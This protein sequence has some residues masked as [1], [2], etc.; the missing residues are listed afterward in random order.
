MGMGIL[1]GFG[2]LAAVSL[3]AFVAIEVQALVL[4]KLRVASGADLDEKIETLDLWLDALKRRSRFNGTILIARDGSVVFQR[5]IGVADIE[6]GRPITDR[7]AFNLASVSKHITAFSVLLLEHEGRLSRDDLLSK[8]LPELGRFDGVTLNH[9][10]YHS[11]G[12]PE[13]AMNTGLSRLLERRNTAMTADML[14][15]WLRTSAT[16]ARFAP[17]S[18]VAYCNSNYVLLAE[19]VARVSGRAFAEFLRVRL[20]EPLG[21]RHTAVVNKIVN[22]TLLEDRARGFRKRFVHFGS[23]VRHDLNRF[24]GAAG[25]GNIYSTAR[26]LVIWDQALREGRLLPLEVYAE[27]YEPYRLRPGEVAKTSFFG[28]PLQGGL[29]WNVQDKPVVTAYGSWLGF[30]NVYRREIESGAVLVVLTNSGGFLRTAMM[31]ERVMKM[32]EKP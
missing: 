3:A 8:H 25:D 17:G 12:I 7:T 2:S 14:I 21:M 13:Y 22:T 20:F 11:S 10:L 5:N 24:D 4:P 26:D 15:E 6:D 23:Y 19:V 28:A 27:A 16:R 1:L 29:G 32:L 30:S 18:K 31:A 9:L